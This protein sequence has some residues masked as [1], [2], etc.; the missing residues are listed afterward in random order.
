MNKLTIVFP[1]ALLAFLALELLEYLPLLRQ[2]AAVTDRSRSRWSRRDSALCLV[3]TL[4]YV[5]AAFFHLGDRQGIESFCRFEER[6]ETVTVTLAEPTV[7]G[8]L[9]YY[10]GLFMAGYNLQVSPDGS[11]YRPAGE[12]EQKHADLFKWREMQPD[13]VAAIPVRYVRLVALG[14]EWLGELA[15]YDADGNRLDAAAMEY[16]AEYTAL[17]DEQEKIPA[18]DSFMNGTYFDEIYHPARRWSISKTS[19]PMRSAIRRWAS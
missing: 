7:L 3:L 4:L 10:P 16:P 6:G 1:L 14:R 8:K 9:R 12:L 15:L 17:F 5:P 2:S 11:N 19:S 18:A 13:D